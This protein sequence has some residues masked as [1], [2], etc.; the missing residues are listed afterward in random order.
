MEIVESPRAAQQLVEEWRCANETIGFAPTMGALHDGHL[1]LLEKAR[2]ENTKTVASIFVNPLQFG[3]DED[4][5]KYPRPRQRDIELLEENGCDLLFAPTPNEMYPNGKALARVEVAELGNLWE[6]GAR[7]G[8]FNGVATVVA[9][10]F[11]IVRAHCAYFGE[12]D[13]QQLQIIRQMARDLDFETQIIPCPTL[14]ENDGLAR[15]SRNAYLSKAERRAAA[16]LHRAL[17]AGVLLAQNGER[18]SFVLEREM[19]EVL[20]GEP[21]VETD[22]LAVV[23]A[24]TLEPLPRLD[25]REARVLL[26]AR[27]GAT[28]LIDNLSLH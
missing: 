20:D 23:D 21:L 2:R 27:I 10:L 28:R 8:H 17:C 6:G 18:E 11:N 13:F 24:A 16:S 25:G 4:L 14:R 1:S 15:S 19:N 26:A 22:Y 12:K 9:K 7:P 5:E 3:A